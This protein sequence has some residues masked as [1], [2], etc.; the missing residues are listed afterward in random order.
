M[1]KHFAI[2]VTSCDKYS[3]LWE[4]FFSQLEKNLSVPVKKYLLSNH[5]KYD[6]QYANDVQTICIGDDISWSDGLNKALEN[7]PEEKIFVIVEDFFI[8]KVIDVHFME[9][10]IHFSE[11]ENTQLIHFASLPGS[12]ESQFPNFLKCNNGMPYLISVCGIWD[13]KYMKSLLLSRE[14]AW[15]FEVYG[16]YRAQFSGDRIYCLKSQLF[17]FKNMVQKGAWVKSNLAWAQ[18]LGIPLACDCR[19]IQASSI[20]YFKDFYFQ[21]MSRFPWRMRVGI[22]NFFRKLFVS[23]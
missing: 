9:D 3:D 15:Q 2:L 12:I 14:N 1:Y 5:K 4:G 23:Y 19:P 7:I 17:E 8:S 11:T 18:N 21:L 10:V 6:G 16:S 20:F 13:R 22:L